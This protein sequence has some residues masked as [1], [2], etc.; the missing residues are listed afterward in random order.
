[1]IATWARDF[2]RVKSWRDY[3]VIRPSDKTVV[4]RASTLWVLVNLETRRPIRIPPAMISR[5]MQ[6]TGG[7][8]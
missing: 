2:A 3:A 4:C 6:A 5:F 1:M 8:A 7:G